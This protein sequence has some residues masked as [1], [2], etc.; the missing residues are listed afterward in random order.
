MN[1]KGRHR[2]TLEAKPQTDSLAGVF[3]I[4]ESAHRSECEHA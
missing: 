1:S 2:E 3:Q 4:I